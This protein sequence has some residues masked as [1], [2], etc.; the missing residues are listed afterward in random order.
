MQTRTRLCHAG[1]SAPWPLLTP[2]K[3]LILT[4]AKQAIKHALPLFPQ[5]CPIAWLGG[6]HHKGAIQPQQVFLEQASE[7]KHPPSLLIDVQAV[8]ASPVIPSGHCGEGSEHRSPERQ[9]T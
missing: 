5:T 9:W 3:P 8:T 2:G 7:G 4:L 6:A 1:L